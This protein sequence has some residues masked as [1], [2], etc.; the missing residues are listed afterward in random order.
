RTAA[1]TI[2]PA[3]DFP[4][5][6]TWRSKLSSCVGAAH[7]GVDRRRGRQCPSRGLYRENRVCRRNT[8]STNDEPAGESKG[9]RPLAGVNGALDTGVCIQKRL[10]KLCR[11]SFALGFGPASS[12]PRRCRTPVLPGTAN[13]TEYSAKWLDKRMPALVVRGLARSDN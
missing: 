11:R 4:R 13:G 8:D 10:R 7:F 9:G 1:A 6:L 5:P 3:A 2:F 12:G